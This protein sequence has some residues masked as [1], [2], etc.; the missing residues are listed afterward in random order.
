MKRVAVRRVK[1]SLSADKPQ[2]AKKDSY[3]Y[4]KAYINGYYGDQ[5]VKHGGDRKDLEG[6]SWFLL[7][8]GMDLH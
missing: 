5:F 6:F 8:Y 1:A 4:L 7:R 2:R 3:E